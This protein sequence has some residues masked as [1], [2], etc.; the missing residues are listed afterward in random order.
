MNSKLWTR[1]IL[2]AAIAFAAFGFKCNKQSTPGIPDS[3]IFQGRL[4]QN[5]QLK[6]PDG[7]TIYAKSDVDAAFGPLVDAG[8]H[9][10]FRIAAAPPNNYDMSRFTVDWYKVWLFPRSSH[11]ENPAFLVDA[12]GSSYEGSEWDKDP[13]PNRCLVCAAGMT[14]M[15]GLPIDGPGMVITDD[16]GIMRTIVWFEA[17]HS[18]LWYV[19]P[20][21]YN[22]TQYH[23]HDHGHPIMGYGP[24]SSEKFAAW[25]TKNKD[26]FQFVRIKLPVD[27]TV[28]V[29]DGTGKLAETTI[30]K[31]G[32]VVCVLITK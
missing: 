31:A 7:A 15:Y 14:M 10:A 26:L 25:I 9:D 6:T 32:D 23:D 30:A 11:C 18:I 4:Y 3:D 29:D 8:L 16:M 12:T 20:E 1:I 27:I 28:S 2:V 13:S 22:A 21:R 17:E 19:D 24:P 5:K